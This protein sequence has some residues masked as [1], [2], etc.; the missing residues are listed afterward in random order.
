MK[1]DESMFEQIVSNETLSELA[2][3]ALRSQFEKGAFSP[4]QKLPSEHELSRQLN[5]SRVTLRAALQKLDLQGYIEVKRGVGTFFLGMP[6]ENID[7]G[8][9]R[10]ASVSDVIRERG[11]EPGTKE[12]EIIDAK[13]DAEIAKE[14]HL[15]IGDPV[16]VVNRVRT[17]DGI[18]IIFDNSIF[19]ARIL[20]PDTDPKE[21]GESLFS[22]IEDTKGL[23]INHA[24]ARLQPGIA[25]DF[26]AKKLSTKKGALLIRLVQTHYLLEDDIPIWQ[27]N[28][29]F[30]T[31]K[32]SWYVVRTR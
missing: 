3:N 2:Y 23:H 22:Y 28:L 11:H 4:G 27:G 30:Q 18:P 29:S 25:N 20:S 26:V 6:R 16:T 24:I 8:I 1:K 10:L 17:M 9:E 14:L 21:I 5:I 7:A 31:N 32:F 12:I 19:P 15:A 13:A